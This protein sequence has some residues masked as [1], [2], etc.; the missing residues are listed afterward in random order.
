MVRRW[1]AALAVGWLAA[2]AAEDWYGEDTWVVV[3][4]ASRYFANYRHA[5]NAL[6]MRR[7]SA[8]LGVPRERIL[9]LL[10]EDPTY[11]ARNPRRGEVYLAANGARAADADLV[12]DFANGTAA[13]YSGDAVTPALL[14]ALL[15]GRV[16]PATPLGKR[17]RST[18]ASN[19]LLY[20]TGHGGDGFLKF[21]DSDELAA[22]E[23]AAAIAEMRAKRR[24]KRMV[25]VVET[26]QAA[27]L[28]S[29]F[30]AEATPG[31]L[32][33]ASARVGENA[34]AANADATIGVALADRF[35]E[36]AARFFDREGGGG[37][38][39]DF[40]RALRKAPTRSTLEFHD[41]AWASPDFRQ[42]PLRAFFG[43]PPPPRATRW[44]PADVP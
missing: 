9:V 42:A 35:T 15:T 14:R 3:L 1:V 18:G 27:S 28:F 43:S 6:A 13:D 20:L 21:H 39:A 5:A 19:V 12:A 31:V 38:W 10:A 30:S 34:Y 8:R 25:V 11:D 22:V 23:L 2:A 24:Y 29:A 41:A 33:V 4:G 17:L 26:C 36:Y 16:D 44:P 7:V 40:E 32:G 37:T